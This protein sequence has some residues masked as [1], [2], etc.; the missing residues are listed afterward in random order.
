MDRDD[1]RQRILEA[2]G[3][4]FAEKGPEAA[5]VR[6]I[7]ERAGTNV[8]AIN[9]HFRSKQQLYVET[10]RNAY[11][12]CAAA[13]PMPRWSAEVPAEQRLREFVRAMLRR[14]FAPEVP[15]WH[16]LLIMREVAQPTD[17]CREFV[18]EFV[19]PTFETLQG[20]L[21]ELLPPGV[22]LRQRQM[23]GGSIVGQVLH[24]HHAR[25]VLPLLLGEEYR[26]PDLEALAGHVTDFSLA[27][28]RGVFG[29]EGS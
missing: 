8:G 4:I 21:N 29:G 10:V 18:R 14:V 13:G 23:V 25:H 15:A 26:N 12:S 11:Q 17:A 1:T 20:I 22:S 16:R 19:R 7:C 28:I 3:P 6:D 5:S 24:Y 9:Y 2:A 27:A